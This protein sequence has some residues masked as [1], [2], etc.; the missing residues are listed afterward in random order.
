MEKRLLHIPK[1]LQTHTLNL[2]TEDSSFV[3][4]APPPSAYDQ[5]VV[6]L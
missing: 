1:T 6:H 3:H 2:K 4:P 5:G